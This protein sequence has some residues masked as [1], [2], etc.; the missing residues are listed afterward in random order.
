MQVILYK[1]NIEIIASQNCHRRSFPL[2]SQIKQF[3]SEKK[4][5][6]Q[7]RIFS[8]GAHHTPRVSRQ[9]F[10]SHIIPTLSLHR[11]PWEQE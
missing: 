9:M 2:T 6:A 8:S 1:T 4:Y 11:R 5:L 7:G 10:S 3:K